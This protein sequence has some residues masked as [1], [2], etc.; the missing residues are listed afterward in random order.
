M[1]IFSHGK[2]GFGVV[3]VK[4]LLTQNEQKEIDLIDTRI[5]ELEKRILG[6]H[7]STENIIPITD[8]L[9][10]TNALI[11]ASLVG[12]EA[13][14][15]FMRRLAELDKLLDPA[16][17]DKAVDLSAK[18]EEVLVM[19]P[20]LQQNAKAL[21]QIQKL[22]SVLDS[23]AIKNVPSLTD[24]LEKLTLFYLDRKQEADAT[25]A[26]TMDL[27]Q[28]YNTIIVNITKSFVQFE[29]TVTRLEIAALPRKEAD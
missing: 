6:N 13:V 17:E 20:L 21:Y 3:K 10:N 26:N 8:S 11:N 12:R 19:E 14:S 22:A 5:E 25:T 24:R 2:V 27:L 18:M 28:Q 15:M 7:Q 23:E 16:V 1:V 29:D 4:M 9:I